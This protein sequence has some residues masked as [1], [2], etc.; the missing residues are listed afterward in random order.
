MAPRNDAR[1]SQARTDLLEAE[2]AEREQND[3]IN[4]AIARTDSEV[5]TEAMGDEP[6]GDD[7]DTTLEDM[8]EGLEGDELESEEEQPAGEQQAGEQQQPGGEQQPGER[9]QPGDQRQEPSIPPRVLRATREQARETENLLQQQIRDLQTRLDNVLVQQRQ[10]PQPQP[11]PGQQ[12]Q[13]RQQEQAPDMFSDPEGYRTYLERRAEQR[14]EALV[15][16]RLTAF[17]TQQR[18]ETEQRLNASL[19]AAATGPRAYEFNVAYR[20]LMSLDKT[21]ENAAIVRRMTA[22][23]DVGQAILDWW[24]QS[25]NPEYVE[26][27]RDQIRQTYG[28]PMGRQRVNGGGRQPQGRQQQ[29]FRHEVRI[30]PSLSDA[31]GG[32]SQHT[33]DPDLLDSSERSV[34]DYGSR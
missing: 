29:P 22:Q 13:Q 32:R 30:P 18:Q 21:P 26:Y 1:Q 28:A 20:D 24:E 23:P 27:H 7:V 34:F 9:Q 31:T 10:Q 19:E 4:E 2:R 33:I 5:F 14:A 12:Q 8:G 11:Q 15:T 3:D 16:E 17:Q 25:S 6:I